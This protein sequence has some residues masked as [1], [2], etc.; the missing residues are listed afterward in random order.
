MLSK[1]AKGK[2]YAGYVYVGS[3]P[4]SLDIQGKGK[5]ISLWSGGTDANYATS[6]LF[7]TVDGTRI[8]WG[9]GG[10]YKNCRTSIINAEFISMQ[11]TYD[12]SSSTME[13]QSNFVVPIYSSDKAS[14]TFENESDLNF[15]MSSKR[16]G[17]FRVCADSS[18]L[19][20]ERRMDDAEILESDVINIV[21]PGTFFDFS[22]S[23]AITASTATMSTY[24]YYQIL[25]ER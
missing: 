7:F 12:N 8:Q 20:C 13:L 11:N 22:E 5:I 16:G 2:I 17:C 25:V 10:G 3:E 9:N 18:Q 14:Y 1:L 19:K 24:I 15:L 4:F 21:Q 6:S 23:C